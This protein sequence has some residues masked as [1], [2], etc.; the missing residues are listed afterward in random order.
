M[1]L[2]IS[3][4]KPPTTPALPSVFPLVLLLSLFPSDRLPSFPESSKPSKSSTPVLPKQSARWQVSKEL[5]QTESN[6][7]DI[8]STI[9]QVGLCVYTLWIWY[10]HR[11]IT[12]WPFGC[13]WQQCQVK[14]PSLCVCVMSVLSRTVLSVGPTGESAS[15][16]V[17]E[18]MT[19]LTI[20][21]L[22]NL[23]FSFLAPLLFHFCLSSPTPNHSFSPCLIPSSALSFPPPF[24]PCLLSV[25][26]FPLLR[27]LSFAS[28]SIAPLLLF[29]PPS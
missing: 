25:S 13:P 10:S 22:Q 4:D 17:R 21:P 14:L 6:Y 18:E 20:S 5:Y 26:L 3:N 11:R 28:L 8:L 7:V 16:P 24:S 15:W 9:L 29:P 12:G 2:D 23:S 1:I 27:M 19:C